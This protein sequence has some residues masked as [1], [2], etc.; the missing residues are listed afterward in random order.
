MLKVIVVIIVVSLCMGTYSAINKVVDAR[1]WRCRQWASLCVGSEELAIQEQRLATGLPAS[2]EA[3]QENN[4]ISLELAKK[5]RAMLDFAEMQIP[6]LVRAIE[7]TTILEH[8]I[9]DR[10]DK[11][12]KLLNKA[13]INPEDDT[14]YRQWFL[15]LLYVKKARWQ[16]DHD[17]Q[18]AYL[19][20]NKYMHAPNISENEKELTL[21]ILESRQSL[22][23]TTRLYDHLKGQVDCSK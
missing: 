14:D 1:Q 16:L 7:H 13:G 6:E 21:A 17:L 15:N 11:L 19:A 10:V 5:R 9:Q 23:K 18:T 12:S 3:E 8:D 2:L 4:R 22:S 20:H